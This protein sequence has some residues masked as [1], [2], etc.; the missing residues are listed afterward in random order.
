MRLESRSLTGIYPLLLI[1]AFVGT[2]R[3]IPL[4]AFYGIK[5]DMDAFTPRDRILETLKWTN[6]GLGCRK[7]DCQLWWRR[8]AL[9]VQRTRRLAAHW[10]YHM[11]TPQWIGSR[12]NTN[13]PEAVFVCLTVDSILLHSHWTAHSAPAASAWGFVCIQE[14][15]SLRNNSSITNALLLHSVANAGFCKVQQ[16][17]IYTGVSY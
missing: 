1:R 14:C 17:L 3:T 7:I 5:D 16:W 9:Q 6:A 10:Y 4:K 11:Y 15:A 12:S 2:F 13:V 8:V